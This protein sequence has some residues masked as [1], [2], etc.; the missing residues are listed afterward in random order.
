MARWALLLVALGL[1]GC[2]TAFPPEVM[3]SVD[4]GVTLAQL[5][6]SPAAYV[7]AR[8]ILG[9]EIVATVPR[10]GESEIEVL[11]RPLRGD[12]LPA[13]TDRSEGRFLVRSK[14]FLDPAVYA[15]GRRL[16]VVGTVVGEDERRIGELPYRYAVIQAEAIRLWPREVLIVP[17]YGYPYYSPYYYGYPSWYWGFGWGWGGAWGPYYGG[18][19]W[20]RPYPYPPAPGPPPGQ[21]PPSGPPPGS[22]PPPGSPPGPG[23][24]PPPPPPR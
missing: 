20:Y 17:G 24:A 15:N 2:A 8:V 21:G 22:N 6:A 5:S 13:R 10:T 12:D 7:N 19:G 18:P 1:A 9:G 16:T 3:E 11:E 14:E 23:S 4:R